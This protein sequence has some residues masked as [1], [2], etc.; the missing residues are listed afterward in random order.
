M[1]EKRNVIEMW[2]R[3]LKEGDYSEDLELE[4]IIFY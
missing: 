4:G 2:Y 1:G 3:D